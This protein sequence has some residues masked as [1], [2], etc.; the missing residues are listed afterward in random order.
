MNDFE[1]CIS[2]QE[3]IDNI[4]ELLGSSQIESKNL[5]VKERVM[6]PAH[7]IVVIGETSSGKSTLINSIFDKKLLKESV[8]PTTSIVT[9]LVL[10]TKDPEYKAIKNDGAVEDLNEE[11]FASLTTNP[12]EDLHRL[13]YSGPGNHPQ[14]TGLRIFDTPGYGSLETRHEQ[15]LKDFIPESDF[16]V[17]TVSYRVGIGDDDYQFLKYVG[18]VIDENVEVILVVN[19]AP[20]DATLR[21]KRV[22]E[23]RE[24]VNECIHKKAKTFLIKSS[25]EK[26][27]DVSRLWSYICERTSDP[28]KK[29]ELTR[30]LK[31]YQDYILEECKLKIASKI[32]NA[33]SAQVEI[34]AR[35]RIAKEFSGRKQEVIDTIDR[36][37]TRIKVKSVRL[38]DEADRKIKADVEKYIHDES[39]WTKKEETFNFMQQYY[40]PK[41]TDEETEKLIGYIEEEIAQLDKSVEESLSAVIETLE[42]KVRI[43]IP[44]YS[45]VMEGV[46]KKY[47][48]DAIK[49]AAGEMFRKAEEKSRRLSSDSKADT[50]RVNLK[51]MSHGSPDDKNLKHLLKVIKAT[52]LKAITQYLSIFTDSI[53]YLYDSIAWQSK[54]SSIAVEAV[55]NWAA[56]VEGAIRLYLDELKEANKDKIASLFGELEEE[57]TLEHEPVDVDSSVPSPDLKKLSRIKQEIEFMLTG[58]LLISTKDM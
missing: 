47:M 29:E 38:I 36:S 3:K 6:N 57:F 21:N 11:E 19:M 51:N 14:F 16:V 42:N 34:D 33:E 53:F 43:D 28:E 5:L 10:A 39:K 31:D 23:I 52:S 17:Y 44:S 4:V 55:D 40:M 20:E 56:D 9:E 41:L 46:V 32:A 26:T 13:R 2:R 8:R 7:Y 35:L 25:S 1:K 22:M 30:T 50:S 24:A 15:V 54:I 27:P 12:T 49:Q 45:E 58:H 48:G 37:F 18:E